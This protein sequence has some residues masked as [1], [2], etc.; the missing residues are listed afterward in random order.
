M[1][2]EA[3][4]PLLHGF[5]CNEAFEK[6]QDDVFARGGPLLLPFSS[7]SAGLCILRERVPPHIFLLHSATVR[8]SPPTAA[9]RLAKYSTDEKSM[10]LADKIWDMTGFAKFDPEKGGKVG[11][12]RGRGGERCRTHGTS[13]RRKHHTQSSLL[14][15]PSWPQRA[16]H[17]QSVRQQ[18]SIERSHGMALLHND[19]GL[20]LDEEDEAL[21][22]EVCRMGQ[23]TP[24]LH[25]PR[26]R[27]PYHHPAP[28]SPPPSPI[29]LPTTSA[30]CATVAR[31]TTASAAWHGLQLA[32]CR[33]PSPAAFKTFQ[34]PRSGRA[35]SLSTAPT[36][37]PSW[38]C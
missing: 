23:L 24:P 27:L 32:P 10:A 6:L 15:L 36:T 31:T 19:K 8:S 12:R 21:L 22:N 11:S 38:P 29:R 37:T 35:A 5:K 9:T 28:P 34:R 13:P 26:P 33:R 20:F 30:A 4:S 17:F 3:Y 18:T 1:A 14:P 25:N 7:T 16:K 2:S